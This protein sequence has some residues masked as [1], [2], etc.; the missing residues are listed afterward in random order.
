[1]NS[2]KYYSKL[3]T[4]A[5]FACGLLGAGMLPAQSSH[6]VLR[7]G[8][9]LY[10]KQR[11]PLA[12][13]TY[14]RAETDPNAAYNAGNAAYQQGKYEAAAQQFKKSAAIA[15]DLDTKSDALYNL[16]NAYLKLEKYKEAIAAYENSLRLRPNRLQTTPV[17][18]P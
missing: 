2:L 8:D 3:Y 18:G 4:A 17:F 9:R 1:M 13:N 7:K 5:I 11:Y 16:G 12:E 15:S 6:T 14:R 10:D